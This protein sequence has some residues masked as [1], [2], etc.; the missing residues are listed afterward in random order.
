VNPVAATPAHHTVS[1]VIPVKDDGTEL[2]RCL[3][4][5]ER[6]TRRPDEIIVVDNGSSDA[7][8]EI[9]RQADA[10]VI[11]CDEPGIPAASALGYDSA[12]GELILRLD[13]DCVPGDRW[14]QTLVEAFSRRP[15]VGA[16]TGG[17]HFIDG[18]RA[19]RR[20]LAVVY[21]GTYAMV[22][23][24]SLGHLPVFGSNLAIRRAAWRGIR[25]QVHRHDPDL[26]DDFDLAFHLGERVPIRFV[27]GAEMGMSM[28]PFAG[29]RGFARRTR[30]GL[31]TVLV[32]WPRDFPPV[33]WSRLLLRQQLLPWVEKRRVEIAQ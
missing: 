23:M 3:R 31:R 24:I 2:S 27:V 32:H 25:A 28:R 1:V 11:R 19:L 17:A 13:A 30:W 16:L 5:L 15:D 4:A 12:V 9:A 33:R 14:I 10:R 22:G 18:P 8:A 20:P 6:Q 26:H 7:S 29:I 21:L